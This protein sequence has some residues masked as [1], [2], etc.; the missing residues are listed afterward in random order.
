MQSST[1][2]SENSE[3][4]VDLREHAEVSNAY[5]KINKVK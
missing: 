5:A 4:F 3:A 2:A 1:K